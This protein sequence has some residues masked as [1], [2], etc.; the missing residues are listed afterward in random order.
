MT[1]LSISENLS[2]KNEKQRARQ[3]LYFVYLQALFLALT[4]IVGVWLVAEIHGTSIST[5][6]FIVH[7]V[8]ASGFGLLSAVVGFLAALE[9]QKRVAVSNLALFFITIVAACLG[10]RIFGQQFEQ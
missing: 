8:L 7:G 3:I 6:A 10:V 4:Y 9:S 1:F 5:P 2:R